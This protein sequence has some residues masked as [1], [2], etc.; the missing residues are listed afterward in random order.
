MIES[1]GILRS[2]AIDDLAWRMKRKLSSCAS[3][4]EINAA[5]SLALNGLLGS[6]EQ[7]ILRNLDLSSVP[8]GHLAALVSCVTWRVHIVNVNCD[9]LRILDSVKSRWLSINRQRLNSEETGALVRAMDSRVE[10]VNLGI[11]GIGEVSL[12][13]SAL[14]QYSGQGV[15]ARV[16]SGYYTGVKYSYSEELRRLAKRIN[17]RVDMWTE[18]CVLISKI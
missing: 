12:D 18:N 5:G 7:M 15:C 13:I 10:E 2:E 11:G 14:T 3:L 17:W 4:P 8:A 1:R 6:V 16:N 9:L